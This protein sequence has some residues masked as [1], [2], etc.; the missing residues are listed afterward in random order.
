MNKRMKKKQL[1]P[2]LEKRV[3]ELTIKNAGLLAQVTVLEAMQKRIVSHV[4]RLEEQVSKNVEA[5]NKNF[6]E[7]RAENIKLR[8]EIDKLKKPWFKR[9]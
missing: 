8:K 7:L 5:T 3:A 6:D 1:L 4:E 9:K 2:L